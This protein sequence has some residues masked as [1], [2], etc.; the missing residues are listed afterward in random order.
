MNAAF[1]TFAVALVSVASAAA[2]GIGLADGTNAAPAT[3]VVKLERVVVVGQSAAPV[4][5][6]AKLPRVV[7]SQ[8]RAASP[9][10]VMAQAQAP[11][12]I[13]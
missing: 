3:E 4:A 11:V 12:W 10:A 7:I 1:H 9:E 2:I 8:R 5:V 6:V 13:A